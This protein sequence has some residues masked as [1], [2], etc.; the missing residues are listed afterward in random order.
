MDREAA[1]TALCGS[2]WSPIYLQAGGREILHDMIREFEV[3]AQ[4]RRT[5]LKRSVRTRRKVRREPREPRKTGPVTD[6]N[7]IYTILK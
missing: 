1:L 6:D 7:Y 4:Q 2:A 3:V 5:I